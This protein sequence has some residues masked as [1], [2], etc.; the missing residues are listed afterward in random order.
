MGAWS[1]ESFGNDDACDWA[2]QLEG[3][4]GLK[5][6]EATL[7]KVLASGDEY[8]EAP[9]ASEAI[10]AAEAVARLQGN[11]GRRDP[12][13]EAVDT[14]VE[15]VKLTPSQ[16]LATKA[17]RALDRVVSEPSELLEL[18]QEGEEGGVWLASIAELKA[19]IDA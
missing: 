13:S 7:D 9:E 14:W 2:S 16:A 6:V 11:S 19:R 17:R 4:Q 15:E 12:Y 10:A 1:H 8:L 3:T 5:L 18:W